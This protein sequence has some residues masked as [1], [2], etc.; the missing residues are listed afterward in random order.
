M[1]TDVL[2]Q[3]GQEI[4]RCLLDVSQI[5]KEEIRA[6]LVALSTEMDAVRALLDQPPVAPA[7]ADDTLEPVTVRDLL[8]LDINA[9]NISE[10]REG[11]PTYDT[12]GDQN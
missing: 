10:P 5:Y 3:G 4:D 7:P 1:I 11:E 2:F 9:I 8:E 6:R 12:S